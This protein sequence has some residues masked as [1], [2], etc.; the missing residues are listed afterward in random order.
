MNKSYC[1]LFLFQSQKKSKDIKQKKCK[2]IQPFFLLSKVALNFFTEIPKSNIFSCEN[3]EPSKSSGNF[4][5]RKYLSFLSSGKWMSG[6]FLT[7]LME[8]PGTLNILKKSY[9]TSNNFFHKN[10]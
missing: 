1:K 7:F 3:V 10:N 4:I 5:Q 9:M 8:T 6:I 2:S